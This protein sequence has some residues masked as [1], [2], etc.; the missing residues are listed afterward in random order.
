MSRIFHRTFDNADLQ[1]LHTIVALSEREREKIKQANGPIITENWLLCNWKWA[2]PTIYEFQSGRFSWTYSEYNL[3]S[4]T[5][6]CSQ[7]FVPEKYSNWISHHPQKTVI[8]CKHNTIKFYNILSAK[9]ESW[10]AYISKFNQILEY[11]SDISNT[12]MDANKFPKIIELLK[13]GW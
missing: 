3:Y 2:P 1:K 11:L 5:Q 4:T 8:S 13:Q 6:P 12:I 7:V 10:Y 9:Q